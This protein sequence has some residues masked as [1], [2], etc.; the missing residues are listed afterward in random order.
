MTSQA[1]AAG[2]QRWRIAALFPRLLADLQFRRY[3]TAQTISMFGDQI[4]GIAIPLAAVIVLHAGAAQ[5]GYLTALQWLPSLLFGLHAGVWV[6]RRGRRRATMIAADL[7]RF[8]L[9]ASLPACY[10]LGVLTLTQLLI[11]TFLAGTLSVLFS[12]SDSTLFVSLLRTDQYV[13]GN[14][15]IYGSRALSFVGGPSVGGLLVQLLSAPMAI[16]A[17]ALSFLGSALFLS[18]TRAR[19][20]AADE[21]GTGAVMA[22]ARFIVGSPVVRSSLCGVAVINFFDLMFIALVMLYAVRDLHLRP[23]LLGLVYGG[24]AVGGVLGAWATRRLAR[25]IGVGWA[26]V[27]G[28]LLFA[29]PLLLVP[30]AGGPHLLVIGT[31]FAAEFAS[32]FGMMVLDISIGSIFAVVIPDQ[33]RARVSGAFQAVNYGTRPAGAL[34]GGVLGST[35]GLRPTLWIAAAGGTLGALWLLPSPVARFRMPSDQPATAGTRS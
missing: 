25:I 35:I 28:C 30:L 24:A 22:G 11:V 8:A 12:V 5:M 26:Y 31:L 18:R 15:L 16:L 4:S 23:G 32:G 10:L 20:P 33:L 3:W 17:D 14:T 21:T 2:G 27:L 13:E 6:D 1:G 7:G 19:E 34:L 29:A 9:L